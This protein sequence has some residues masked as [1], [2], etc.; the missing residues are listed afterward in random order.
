[1]CPVVVVSK[2]EHDLLS[3]RSTLIHSLR[4]VMAARVATDAESK[5]S[6]Q[7][8]AHYVHHA[9]ATD[10][11]RYAL[12]RDSECY[13]PAGRALLVLALPVVPGRYSVRQS[14]HSD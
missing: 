7:A 12:H 5:E 4:A 11:S 6:D 8:H 10:Q 14:S 1:M 13:P 9:V 3:P 2:P